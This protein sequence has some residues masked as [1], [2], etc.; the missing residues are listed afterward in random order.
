VHIGP[1]FQLIDLDS[2]EAARDRLLKAERSLRF[3][4]AT[5]LQPVSTKKFASIS[6]VL[7]EMPERDHDSDWFDPV[8][9]TYVCLDEP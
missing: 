8:S 7:T 1:V 6:R 2:Q 5:G 9:G 4:E 3:M